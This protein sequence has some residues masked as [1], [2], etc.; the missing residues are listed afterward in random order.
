MKRFSSISIVLA[1]AFW[2]A[3]ATAAVRPHYGGTLHVSMQES[4]QVFDPSALDSSALR[5]LWQLVFETLVRLDDHGR[6]QPSLATSWQAEPGNQRWR[7]QLR[8]G[9]IFSDGTPLD[10][11]TAAA[12]LRA[13]NPQWKVFALG[14]LVMIETESPDANLPAELALPRN[15]ISRAANG[16]LLGTGPFVVAKWDS[17]AKH[18]SLAA[19]NQYW[20]GR[21][22]IDAVEVDT[23]KLYRDQIMLLDLGKSDIAEIPPEAI[24]PAQSG[25]R[26]VLTSAPEELMALVF[27]RDAASSDEIKQRTALARSIDTAA[28]NNVVFQ[29]GGEPAGAMLPDWLS[30]YGLL[31]PSGSAGAGAIHEKLPQSPSWTLSYDSGDQIAHIV[32]DRIL[33]N[34][35][36]VG[37]TLQTTNSPT[38]DIRLVRLPLPSLDPQVGLSELA[39]Q[40]HQTAP[41]FPNASIT[42]NYSA[43]NALLQKR[44][45]IPLLHL[46]NAIAVRPN[47]HAVVVRPDGTWNLRDV[48]LSPETP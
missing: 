41:A 31:F 29:A 32:S 37:I 47:V 6:P 19:N 1:S 10:S 24:R 33:L 23:G 44:R 34:A 46:R 39:R 42:A 5:S 28:L 9:V 27:S 25:N 22:F 30:G 13:A 35:R 38:S 14:D 18:L 7:L 16:T 12:S 40:T 17:A 43:E 11:G 15:S 3:S 4:P 8:N 26:L 36:D 21:P 45:I 20:A 2:L 48:W